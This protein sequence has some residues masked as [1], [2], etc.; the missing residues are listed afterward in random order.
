MR[1][2]VLEDFETSPV[3][4]NLPTPAPDEGELLIRVHASSVNPVDNGIAAGLLKSMVEYQFPGHLWPRLRR[5]GRADG[6]RR[7]PLRRR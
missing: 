1:A 2:F 7:D 6:R 5:R 4:R 3:L